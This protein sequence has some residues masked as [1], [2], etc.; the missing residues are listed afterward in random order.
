MSKPLK[1]KYFVSFCLLFVSGLLLAQKYTE[2]GKLKQFNITVNYDDYTVKTQ[3]LSHQE[4]RKVDNELFYLWYASQKLMETKG[5]YE[6]KLIHGYYTSFYLNNQLREQ[7]T[8]RYGLKHKEWKAWYPDGKLREIIT[9]RNGRKNGAYTLYNDLG[10]L[11][12]KSRFKND[13]LHG[14]FYTYSGNGTV[15]EV[16]RYRRGEEVIRKPKEK[17]VKAGKKAPTEKAPSEK[18]KRN[19]KEKATREPKQDVAPTP[20]PVPPDTQMK[21]DTTARKVPFYKRWFKKKSKAETPAT[22]KPTATEGRQA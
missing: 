2:P 7:G 14:K 4:S 1:Y 5:G 18:K 9:W 11:M 8:V 16:R 6:G 15:A 3:M 20:A 13:K 17:K 21:S 19:R 12:A 22:P 10:Q